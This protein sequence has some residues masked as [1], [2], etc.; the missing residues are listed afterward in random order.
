MIPVIFILGF[1]SV[2]AQTVEWDTQQREE[3]LMKRIETQD[4]RLSRIEERY[5]GL[6]EEANRRIDIRKNAGNE[7]KRLMNVH[8]SDTMTGTCIHLQPIWH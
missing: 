8:L 1:V 2:A 4:H 6:K 7:A 5:N 3:R